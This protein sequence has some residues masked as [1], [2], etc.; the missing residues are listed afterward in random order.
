MLKNTEVAWPLESALFCPIKDCS[1]VTCFYFL[2][3]VI[4]ANVSIFQVRAA[5]LPNQCAPCGVLA[6]S[7]KPMLINA[8]NCSAVFKA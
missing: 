7:A 8:D 1:N 6:S 4:P 5:E 3:G 2:A